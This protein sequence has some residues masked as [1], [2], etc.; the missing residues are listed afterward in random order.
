MCKRGNFPFSNLKSKSTQVDNLLQ[1]AEEIET[2]IAEKSSWDQANSRQKLGLVW[3]N[4]KKI[5]QIIKDYFH[6]PFFLLI[7]LCCKPFV[8]ESDRKGREDFLNILLAEFYTMGY[9]FRISETIHQ[10]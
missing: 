2:G 3:R 4:R 7:I 1:D 10:L 9:L 5:S 8:L 6:L